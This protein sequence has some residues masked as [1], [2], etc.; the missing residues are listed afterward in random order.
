MIDGIV[1]LKSIAGDGGAGGAGGAEPGFTSL[2]AAM[3]YKARV[4]TREYVSN[5]R[6]AEAVISVQAVKSSQKL[7]ILILKVDS[8]EWECKE[9]IKQSNGERRCFRPLMAMN[10]LILLDFFAGILMI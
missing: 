5:N 9:R 1:V 4:D 2:W 7:L 3:G 8:D 10:G 6:I